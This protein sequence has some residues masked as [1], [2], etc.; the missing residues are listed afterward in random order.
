[1]S[2]LNCIFLVP[3]SDNVFYSFKFYT[4]FEF[5]RGTEKKYLVHKN[6]KN[7]SW[8][9][10]NDNDEDDFNPYFWNQLFC[11]FLASKEIFK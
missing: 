7:S 3:L 4:V 2:L 1:M 11:H 8:N 6:D 9:I 10:N 5:T